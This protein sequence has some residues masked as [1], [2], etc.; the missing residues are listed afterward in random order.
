MKSSMKKD[1]TYDTETVVVEVVNLIQWIDLTIAEKFQIQK[2][3]LVWS[4]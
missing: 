1:M 3:F 2:D 4:L